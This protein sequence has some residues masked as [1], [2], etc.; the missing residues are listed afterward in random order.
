MYLNSRLSVVTALVITLA[1]SVCGKKFA[2]KMYKRIEIQL[3]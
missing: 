1:T 3:L 2:A